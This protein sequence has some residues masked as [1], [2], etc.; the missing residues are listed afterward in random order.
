VWVPTSTTVQE[1][2]IS[3]RMDREGRCFSYNYVIDVVPAKLLVDNLLS[4]FP[5]PWELK[6]K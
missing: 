1:K 2:L 3:S 5:P 4:L 6:V